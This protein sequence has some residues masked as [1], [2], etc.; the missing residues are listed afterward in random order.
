MNNLI[1]NVLVTGASNGI[2]IVLDLK[3]YLQEG[4]AVIAIN[5]RSGNLIFQHPR[6]TIIQGDI[7][8]EESI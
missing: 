3:N 8:N 6:L 7:I 4:A 1:T 5:H 2:G